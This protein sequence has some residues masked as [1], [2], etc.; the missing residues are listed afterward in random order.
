MR[1]FYSKL[2]LF[3]EYTIIKGSSALAIPYERYSGSWTFDGKNSFSNEILKKWCEFLSHSDNEIGVDIDAFRQDIS[4]GLQFNSNIPQGYGVGSSGAL[5]AAL[6]HEYVTK[7]KGIYN[8]KKDVFFLK[9]A[10]KILETFFHGKG[11]G[12]D[13]LVCYLNQSLLFESNGE[14]K[15]SNSDFLQKNTKKQVCF[16]INT[17]LP[18]KTEPLVQVF[19]QKCQ[20]KT[21]DLAC[22]KELVIYNNSNLDLV[23]EK[24]VCTSYL[25]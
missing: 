12:T 22:K 6:L 17:H 5:V 10:F 15:K 3:G 20:E 14:I 19:S 2:L 18:R 24:E 9:N 23:K 8:E 4:N 1:R 21:F 25:I 13:P 7:N 11:S 16:L